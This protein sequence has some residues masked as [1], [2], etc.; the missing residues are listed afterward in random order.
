MCLFVLYFVVVGNIP[1]IWGME[2]QRRHAVS[3]CERKNIRETSGTTVLLVAFQLTY[4]YIPIL[5]CMCVLEFFYAHAINKHIV[6][7][8]SLFRL[9]IRLNCVQNLKKLMKTKKRLRVHV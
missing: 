8:L 3:K 4:I 9:K 2:L 1:K 6:I 5:S 7:V